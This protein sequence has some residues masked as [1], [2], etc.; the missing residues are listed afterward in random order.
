MSVVTIAYCLFT[1]TLYDIMQ[2]LFQV[3]YLYYLFF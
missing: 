2:K 3:V 1:L